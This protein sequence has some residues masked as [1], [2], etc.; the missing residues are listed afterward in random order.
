LSLWSARSLRPCDCYLWG[1]GGEAG[2]QLVV[3]IVSTLRTK[4]KKS[5]DLQHGRYL[6]TFFHQ[7]RLLVVFTFDYFILYRSF[8][9]VIRSEAMTCR[10]ISKFYI[11]SFLLIVLGFCVFGIL[12]FKMYCIVVPR[13]DTSDIFWSAV[14]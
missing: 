14:S 13:D 7:Q 8:V 5:S 2:R 1:R 9:R 10:L 11:L 6:G 3:N 12:Y 4:F